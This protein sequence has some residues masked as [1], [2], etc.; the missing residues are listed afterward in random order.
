[1]QTTSRRAAIQLA[2]LALMLLTAACV[3]AIDEPAKA[4]TVTQPPVEEWPMISEQGTPSA[5]SAPSQAKQIAERARLDLSERCG[6]PVSEIA[7]VSSDAVEWP[8][9]SLGCPQPGALYA[10]VLTP[11]YQIVLDMRAELYEYHTDAEGRQL[12]LCQG[13]RQRL[14]AMRTTASPENAV[15][16]AQ[17]D[18]AVR[19]GLSTT[20]IAMVRITQEMFPAGDLGCPCPKCP[21][22][23]MTGLVEAQRIILT[24]RGKEYEYRAR[25]MRVVFCGER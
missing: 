8:N 10:Q 15:T 14:D 9:A 1:M 7:I 21:A 2:L 12:I 16:A 18:L 19:L 17:E 11:G 6:V 5:P 23:P 25:G 22:S 13:D 3:S 24:A 4:V 20:E